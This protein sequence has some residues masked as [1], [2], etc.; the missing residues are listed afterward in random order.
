MSLAC[1]PRTLYDARILLGGIAQ[2]GERL[3]GMQEVSG[4]IPLTST[5]TSINTGL[6][7][8]F[9]LAA[10]HPIHLK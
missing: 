4:S 8:R 7:G 9:F 3:H 6:H 1:P 2:L 5:I 10:H